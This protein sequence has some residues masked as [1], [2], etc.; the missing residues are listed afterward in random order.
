MITMNRRS[1]MTTRW[2]YIILISCSW[3]TGLAVPAYSQSSAS[4]SANGAAAAV[5]SP[6]MQAGVS[7]TQ[8]FSPSSNGGGASGSSVLRGRVVSSLSSPRLQQPLNA[9]TTIGSNR[10]SGSQGFPNASALRTLHPGFVSPSAGFHVGV[11]GVGSS[12]PANTGSGPGNNSST[13]SPSHFRTSVY[14]MT[15]KP[16][17]NSSDLLSG[18][19]SSSS[20]TRTS[21]RTRYENPP[22]MSPEEKYGRT[23][24]KSSRK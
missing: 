5:G 14:S 21:G 20:R 9:S 23:A 10:R 24:P 4:L 6:N 7:A 8:E 17:V 1:S 19:A 13:R 18:F 22:L 12:Q 11:A 3:V 15:S 16:R 2:L